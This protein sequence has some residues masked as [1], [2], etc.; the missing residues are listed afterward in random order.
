MEI[1]IHPHESCGFISTP[2]LDRV[3]IDFH[4]LAHRFQSL[5]SLAFNG[6]MLAITYYAIRILKSLDQT[7]WISTTEQAVK[8]RFHY[9]SFTFR[10]LSPQIICLCFTTTLYFY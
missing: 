10:T 9:P 2:T 1:K 3:Q 7:T 8:D 6:F 4:I 5:L